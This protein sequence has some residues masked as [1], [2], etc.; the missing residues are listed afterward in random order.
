[1]QELAESWSLYRWR[2]AYE[3]SDF[4]MDMIFILLAVIEFSAYATVIIWFILC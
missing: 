1:M 3:K 2:Q 4:C